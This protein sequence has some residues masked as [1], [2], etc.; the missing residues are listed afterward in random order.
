MLPVAVALQAATFAAKLLARQANA[1]GGPQP[2]DEALPAFTGDRRDQIKLY[3]FGAP[4]VGTSTF[5][6]YLENNMW[7]RYR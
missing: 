6:A 4:R 7:E 3:T 2:R 1:I 5:A